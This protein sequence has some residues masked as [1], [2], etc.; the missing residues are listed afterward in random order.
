MVA[1]SLSEDTVVEKKDGKHLIFQ[2]DERGYGI[3]ILT[4]NE[5]I[6]VMEVTPIPKAPSF[7]KGII[8]LRGKII[9][10]MDLRLKFGMDEKA[11]NE[12]TCI[13][14]VNINIEEVVRQI[15]VVVDIVSEVVNI[16][17]SDIEEAPKFGKRRGDDFLSGIGKIKDKVV[18]LLNIEKVIYTEEV[19]ELLQEKKDSIKKTEKEV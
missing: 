1:I 15:G 14:I 2:I 16:L 9:P 12:Q 3:P 7:I 8:N 18:M 17:A 10:V 4:V 6:G 13:I 11:Y 5:I 19:I